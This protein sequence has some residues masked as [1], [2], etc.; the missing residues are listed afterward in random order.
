MRQSTSRPIRL[1]IA[2]AATSTLALTA[3]GDDDGGEGGGGGASAESF[4]DE[5]AALGET[6]DDA[7]DEQILESL[8]SVA[9][10]T[11]DEISDEMGQLVDAFEQ[12]QSFD[13][14]TA[15]EEEM[16][17]FVEMAGELDAAS[18]SIEEFAVENCP[19]LP[20]DVFGTD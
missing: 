2:L 18:A 11:P 9:D 12:L 7:T 16:G 10:V 14:E 4:C 8:R 20:A 3:C 17:R 13:P 5:I 6:G 15:S 19:D 1:A